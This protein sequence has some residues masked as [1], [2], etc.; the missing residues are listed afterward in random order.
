M[1]GRR[2]ALVTLANPI[3]RFLE[4][5]GL[6]AVARQLACDGETPGLSRWV[7]KRRPAVGPIQLDDELGTDC[8][9]KLFILGL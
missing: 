4:Y 8:A 2:S 6:L 3:G 5:V 1:I 7:V 9:R